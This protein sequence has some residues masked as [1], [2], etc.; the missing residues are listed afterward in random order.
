MP[1]TNGLRL[2]VD[3]NI[4]TKP[5]RVEVEFPDENLARRY[6][7]SIRKTKVLP[8]EDQKPKVV[9]F[10]LPAS[11]RWLESNRTLQGFIVHFNEKK[12]A[13]AWA[14]HICLH[15]KGHER[16]IVIKQYWSE[17]EEAA[18][19]K[20]LPQLMP[21]PP[22]P[23]PKNRAGTPPGDAQRSIGMVFPF[24]KRPG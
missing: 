11:A 10:E 2:Y 22:P 8:R 6:R 24:H 19:K 12:D 1:S 21:P 9:A 5:L 16:Q 20:H 7:E 18:L 14:D 4:A 17:D 23:P 15:V 3:I 13:D